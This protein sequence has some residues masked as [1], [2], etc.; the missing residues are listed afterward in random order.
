MN[1]YMLV[2]DSRQPMLL[3]YTPHIT[4]LRTSTALIQLYLLA[5]VEAAHKHKNPIRNPPQKLL[6]CVTDK[7][8]FVTVLN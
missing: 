1:S 6:S 8:K 5:L 2:V 4:R 7:V 3:Q